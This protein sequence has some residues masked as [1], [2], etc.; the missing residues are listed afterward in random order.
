MMVEL[1]GVESLTSWLSVKQSSL[2]SLWYRQ[3]QIGF[4]W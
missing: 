3:Q 4:D 1:M 2:T